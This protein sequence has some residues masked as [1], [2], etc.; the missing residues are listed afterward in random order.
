MAEA[1]DLNFGADFVMGKTMEND[2]KQ[3]FL[4]FFID[5]LGGR[6]AQFGYNMYI[7][8]YIDSGMNL[9][10][11]DLLCLSCQCHHS[12]ICCRKMCFLYFTIIGFQVGTPPK[13]NNI[14]P[15]RGDHL[16]R[17]KDRLPISLFFR[18]YVYVKFQVLYL[19]SS[20]ES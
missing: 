12:H 1:P 2:G 17:G 20:W 4:M 16:F 5:F 6:F 13:F 18:G 7:Y 14:A 15:Q 3:L 10:S 11:T 19:L 9:T 8:I